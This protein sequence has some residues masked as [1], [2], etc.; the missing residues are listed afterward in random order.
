MNIYDFSGIK[1]HAHKTNDFIDDEIFIIDKIGKAA[2]IK[3][4]IS[5]IILKS[6]LSIWKICRC[7]IS[8]QCSEICNTK[9]RGLFRKRRR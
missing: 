1:Q 6:L 2:I 5:L 9:C 7:N 3:L 8:P 4:L